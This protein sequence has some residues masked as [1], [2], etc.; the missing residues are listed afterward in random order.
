VKV[1]PII[2]ALFADVDLVSC[3]FLD[4]IRKTA[5]SMLAD[6]CI[7]SSR[8]YRYYGAQ[9]VIISMTRSG[10]Q[11]ALFSLYK[12]ARA[13]TLK[14]R[15]GKGGKG[16]SKFGCSGSEEDSCHPSTTSE[17]YILRKASLSLSI[18]ALSP[19]P[20]TLSRLSIHF[21]PPFTLILVSTSR[22]MWRLRIFAI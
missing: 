19:A 14:G 9:S 10:G 13:R 16:G 1:I 17:V 20:I 22:K 8:E 4:K 15:G 3:V 18:R 5:G 2:D 12:Y 7:I 11:H 21:P 6:R